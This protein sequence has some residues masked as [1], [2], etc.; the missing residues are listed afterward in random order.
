[1]SD[2][3]PPTQGQRLPNGQIL[4]IDTAN[5]IVVAI[6]NAM[7]EIFRKHGIDMDGAGQAPPILLMHLVC[8][9]SFQNG[10]TVPRI[11][12]WLIETVMEKYVFFQEQK[13]LAEA[14]RAASSPSS[15][16]ESE[17]PANVFSL[18]GQGRPKGS[19]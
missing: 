18:F 16:G 15:P 9:M 10:V 1:M 7:E 6:Y 11:S 13:R 2:S 12:G 5:A 17:K 4:T 19:A 3:T 14:Q 8:M